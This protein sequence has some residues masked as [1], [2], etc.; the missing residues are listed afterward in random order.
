MRKA[1]SGGDRLQ[2]GRAYDACVLDIRQVYFAL[3]KEGAHRDGF[4]AWFGDVGQ[5][6][7]GDPLWSF[8]VAERNRIEK[9]GTNSLQYCTQMRG[10]TCD[11]GAP[12]FPDAQLV[13][14]G[15]F[16]WVRD[17]GGP[18]EEWIAFQ[19]ETDGEYLEVIAIAN[20]PECHLGKPLLETDPISLCVA[21]I[22]TLETIVHDARD[23]FAPNTSGGSGNTE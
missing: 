7:K 13:I 23:R 16:W 6:L 5:M 22:E 17:P 2:F 9:E 19:P 3:K 10:G 4:E 1:V 8:L 15:G 21:A 18:K 11:T 14:E 12:P 20:A